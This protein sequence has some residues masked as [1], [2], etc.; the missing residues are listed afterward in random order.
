MI[1]YVC[2]EYYSRITSEGYLMYAKFSCLCPAKEEGL[3]HC[4]QTLYHLSH[5]GSPIKKREEKR[6][7][8]KIEVKVV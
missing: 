7:A 2:L 6:W 1:D 5:Q 4:R 3:P 8:K